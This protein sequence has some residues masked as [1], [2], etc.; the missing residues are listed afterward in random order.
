MWGRVDGVGLNDK[1]L[2]RS[3]SALKCCRCLETQNRRI[4]IYR[5]GQAVEALDN[6]SELSGEDM[7][8]GFMVSLKR[9]WD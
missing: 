1:G 8:P 3:D 4:E 7:L 9:V 2:G 6:P 5:P